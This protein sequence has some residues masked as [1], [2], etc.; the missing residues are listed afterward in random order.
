MLDQTAKLLFVSLKKDMEAKLNRE[1]TVEEK[2]FLQDLSK[3][4]SQ[5]MK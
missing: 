1:L 3:K 4:N 2:K 5:S